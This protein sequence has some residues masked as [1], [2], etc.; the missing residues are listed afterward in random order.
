MLLL[1][2]EDIIRQ[3]KTYNETIFIITLPV[4]TVMGTYYCCL[5]RYS[6]VLFCT[7]RNEL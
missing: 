2:L 4:L 5:C 6:A 7:Q 1:K 3:I